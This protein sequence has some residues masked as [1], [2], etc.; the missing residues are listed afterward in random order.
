MPH[1]QEDKSFLNAHP[2]IGLYH[3][4]S[5]ALFELK[6]LDDTLVQNGIRELMYNIG[7]RSLSVRKSIAW[8]IKAA[9]KQVLLFFVSNLN[10]NNFNVF[11]QVRIFP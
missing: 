1:N 3:L 2:E 4:I 6:R 9:N 7:N 10:F 5:P 8:G 11:S